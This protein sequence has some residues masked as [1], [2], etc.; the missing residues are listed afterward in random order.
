MR[1]KRCLIRYATRSISDAPRIWPSVAHQCL[2]AA[3]RRALQKQ[4]GSSER[5]LSLQRNIQANA[6]NKAPEISTITVPESPS[7]PEVVSLR[8]ADADVGSASVT[9]IVHDFVTPSSSKQSLA[10]LSPVDSPITV[11]RA[12]VCQ[13]HAIGNAM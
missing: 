3:M 13:L 2:R 7:A 12:D 1:R 5:G 4:L 6:N 10:V 8:D 11:L 9:C